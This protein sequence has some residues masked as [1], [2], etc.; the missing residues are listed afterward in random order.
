MVIKSFNNNCLYT[1]FSALPHWLFK[2]LYIKSICYTDLLAKWSLLIYDNL[3]V[4]LPIRIPVVCKPHL[5]PW[6]WIRRRRFHPICRPVWLQQDQPLVRLAIGLLKEEFFSV[7]LVSMYL[8]M[9]QAWMHIK[10]VEKFNSKDDTRP[11]YFTKSQRKIEHVSE[12]Y[13]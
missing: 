8:S 6:N 13:L 7:L 2:T 5:P 3:P 4:Q 9:C 1:T 11:I 12:W 10:I